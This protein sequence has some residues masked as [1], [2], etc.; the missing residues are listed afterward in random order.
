LLVITTMRYEVVRV[1]EGSCAAKDLY[2]VHACPKMGR[3]MGCNWM[4]GSLE[5]FVAGD[6]HR[7]RLRGGP[8]E[9]DGH[10]VEP[11]T[12]R[13]ADQ[14]LPRFIAVTTDLAKRRP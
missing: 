8:F 7:L 2:V 9:V 10:P 3:S 14:A 4:A 1:I 5:R 12:D 11:F 6:V 13:F